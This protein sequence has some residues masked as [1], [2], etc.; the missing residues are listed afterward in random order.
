MA[1]S[2]RASAR[3]SSR[4]ARSMRPSTSSTSASRIGGSRSAGRACI[5][6][7]SSGCCTAGARRDVETPRPQELET[8]RDWLRYAVSRFNQAGVVVRPRHGQRVRRSGRTCCCMRCICRSTASSRFSMRSC[9]QS[10]RNE[11]AA[12]FDAARRRPGARG[13]PHAGSVARRIPLSCRRARDHPAFV[14]RRTDAG[15]PRTLRFGPID[16]QVCARSMHGLRLPRRYCSRMHS[17]M[18]T[19]TP[20]TSVPMRSPSRSAT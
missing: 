2:L 19:S 1:A 13:V 16:D 17:G 14:H 6:A 3:R 5:A 15:G 8:L 9:R 4:S 20:S 18:R 7:S 10:E 11:L 12:L